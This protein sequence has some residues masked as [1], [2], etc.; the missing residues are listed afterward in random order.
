VTGAAAYAPLDHAAL[1]RRI[2]ELQDADGRIRWIDGGLWDPWNHVESAL[3]LVAA[4]ELDAAA[5]A[6]DHLAE[7]QRS[8]G[9]WLA[10]MGC[11]AALVDD[12]RRIGL[13]APQVVDTNFAAY[14][15]IGVWRQARAEGSTAAIRRHA[16]MIER[17]MAFVLAHQRRDGSVAWRALDPGESANDVDALLSGS[18]SI[19]K[20][21]EC[22]IRAF[23][24]IGRPTDH[25][26]A[27]RSRLGA[28]LRRD[29]A[30]TFAPKGEFAMDW[31][32]PVL[33]GALSPAE[34]RARLAA[35]WRRFVAPGWGCRCVA[36]EP[37]TTAAETAELAIALT[38][39]G[40]HGLAARLLATLPR[41]RAPGGDAWMGWQFVENVPWPE[42]RPS[43]TAAAVLLA[44]EAARGADGSVFLETLPEDP[45]GDAAGRLT[46][47]A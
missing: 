25:W 30:A 16:D 28:A 32:Y 21:L 27:A 11:A 5:R 15:A 36:D 13:D 14:P 31:Y 10:D 7:T 23:E 4:G 8:D 33:A 46:Q 44:E 9:A 3:G 34:A 29:D 22:A 2:L 47:Y 38:I 6:L 26:R 45:R 19:F 1:V 42:E 37:W 39:C 20:S 18:A 41:L 43:W 40:A 35:G 17:A 12:G 24:A